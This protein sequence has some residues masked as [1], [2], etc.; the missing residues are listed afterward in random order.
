M[1]APESP[2]SEDLLREVQDFSLVLGGPLYQLLRRARISGDALELVRRRALVLALLAWLP[3]LL[4]SVLEGRAFGESVAVPFLR[5]IC[6][7]RTAGE[8][9]EHRTACL[10]D[11]EEG[12]VR[13]GEQERD[14]AA[15]S[16]AA[17]ADYLDRDVD[18]LEAIEQHAALFRERLAIA[19][20]EGLDD[21]LGRHLL[22]RVVEERRLVDD[23]RQAPG[24]RG[25]LLGHA[26]V[27]LLARFS[28]L[29]SDAAAGFQVVTG[30]LSHVFER[31]PGVPRFEDARSG[32]LSH[33]LPI[34]RYG[35]DRDLPGL[36]GRNPRQ[37]AATTKL[38]ASRFTSHSKGARRVSSKSL[39]SKTR[40][41]SGVANPPKFIRWQSPQAW[42]S[43]PLVGVASRSKA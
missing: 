10:L 24:R 39:M 37:R 42:T 26:F 2:F 8:L 32:P 31:D 3:L 13:G 6:D 35:L 18:R 11:L 1:A 36:V 7:R 20:E 16:D 25:E 34:G 9:L 29:P 43:I 22:V 28:D 12:V 14:V 33:R 30:E 15:R 5:D 23:A 21:A 38:V 4:L 41:R 27:G 17:H 40:L 19:L